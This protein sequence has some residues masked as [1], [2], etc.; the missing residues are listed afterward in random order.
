MTMDSNRAL[1]PPTAPPPPPSAEI[2]R[3]KKS[4]LHK[5]TQR[6]SVSECESMFQWNIEYEFYEE[7]DVEIGDK[8]FAKQ[9]S[10]W[11]VIHHF[12][13]EWMMLME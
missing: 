3:V 10:G 11:K 9:K 1:I 5:H 12:A 13:R 8:S 6:G 2:Q 7:G 4:P